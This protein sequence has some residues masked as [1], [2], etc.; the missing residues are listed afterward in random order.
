MAT[1][2]STA[3][4]I[5]LVDTS[6]GSGV[7]NLPSTGTR[8]GRSIIFKDR[9]FNFANS[10][11][12]LSTIGGDLFED[13]SNTKVF[14]INGESVTLVAGELGIWFTTQTQQFD[15]TLSKNIQVS[16][17]SAI[18]TTTSISFDSPFIAEQAYISTLKTT[19]ITIQATGST[20]S[21]VLYADSSLQLYWNGRQVG[22]GGA[23]YQ[24]LI[25]DMTNTYDIGSSDSTFK[26]LYLSGNS[27][28]LGNAKLFSDLSGNVF[29][30]NQASTIYSLIG[31]T[32]ETGATGPKGE[33]GPT[34]PTG[35]TGPTGETGSTGPTGQTGTTGPTGPTGQTGSTGPTGQTGPTGHTGPTGNTG[36]TGEKGDKGD[37]GSDGCDGG[38]RPYRSGRCGGCDGS[39]G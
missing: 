14:C 2:L 6:G 26:D 32:G 22:S 25:P 39:G 16:S 37:R 38:A 10:S 21:S 35:I 17:I 33:T 34:G 24:S 36:I 29:Y 31:L 9:N 11:L 5:T 7:I 8:V 19:G 12:T 20:V 1:I 15:I 13:S 18:S 28:Y 3:T 4:G 23:I 27:L 30:Q